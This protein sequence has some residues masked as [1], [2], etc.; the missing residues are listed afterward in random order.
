MS[1]IQRAYAQLRQTFASAAEERSARPGID[2]EAGEFAWVL[3][4]R[5]Q[6]HA[7]VNAIR[8]RNGLPELTMEEV[9]AVE[10]TAMGHIDYAEKYAFRC[11]ELACP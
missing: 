1:S 8:A 5:A 6:M 10:S 4:E 11:A 9:A 2:P 7:G 3:F